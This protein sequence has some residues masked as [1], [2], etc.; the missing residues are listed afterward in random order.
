MKNLIALLF[1]ALPFV[2]FSQDE[3]AEDLSPD[4][5]KNW[6]GSLMLGLSS[7]EG[8][9]HC[10]ED[11][12][13]GAFS[14]ANF[15]F[16]LGV[17]RNFSKV[18]AAG[19]SYRMAKLSGDDNA[20]SAA[21][22]HQKRGFEFTNNL[23]ELTIRVDYTP[24]G[25]KDWKVQPYVYTGIGLAFGNAKT[26]FAGSDIDS[27][28]FDALIAQDKDEVSKAT[29]TAPIGFG[30]KANLTDKITIGLEGGIRFLTNDY[31]DGVSVSANADVNDFY[32]VGGVTV[33]YKF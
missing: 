25:K 6:E 15:A 9:L 21:S 5:K 24:F 13:L 4:F 32:G 3:L 20:F 11:E 19:L 22:G 12:E 29:S 23:H 17:K 30:I 33:G 28:S 1:L 27:P 26:D 31:L 18:F 2:A 16:G 7:Y 10:F 8:D 14:N